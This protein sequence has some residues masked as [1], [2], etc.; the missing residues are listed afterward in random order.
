MSPIPFIGREIQLQRL[1][2]LLQKETASLV[3]I[4]GR[5][6]I[7]KSR[8]IEEFTKNMPCYWFEGLSPTEHITAQHQRDEF[9]HLLSQQ[10]GLPEMKTDNWSKLF[11]QLSEKT[12]TGR[13]VL[14]FDEIT[15]MGHD[16]PTFLPKL[17]NAWDLYF[18]KNPQLIFILCGSVSSWIEKN[19]LSSTGYFGRISQQITLNELPLHH[20]NTLLNANGF[21]RSPLE[22]FIILS[23][24]GGIPWYIE[25]INS[26]YSAPDNIKRLCFEADGLLVE[27]H[28]HI[29]HDLFGKRSDIYARITQFLSSKSAEYSEIAAGI[30]YKSSGTLSDYLDELQTSGYISRD[31]SWSMKSGKRSAISKYRLSDNYL[32]FYYKYIEPKLDRIKYDRYKDVNVT[33]LPG[34]Q[35]ILGLQFENLV[36][37]NRHLIFEKLNIKPEDIIADNPYYQRTTKR[38]AGCQIDYLI[39]TKL[40]T[41]FICEIKFSKNAIGSDVIHDVRDKIHRLVIPKGFSCVPVLIHINGITDELDDSKYFI[42]CIDF[43]L[44][45]TSIK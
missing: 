21:T 23:I 43:S 31:T 30:G 10:T 25:Q 15:W 20:C 45:L 35:S 13:I 4:K 26:A 14:V 6:R 22:K 19:I 1:N 7:G 37:R 40:N 44:Y 18:K 42:E 38:S 39:Q 32:R 27:E 2:D 34:W 16:D 8:L 17:K 5:R 3:V 29:F 24:T 12:K 41:L 36:L 28:R 33:T 9:S 11:V